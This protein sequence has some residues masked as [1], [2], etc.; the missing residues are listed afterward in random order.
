MSLDYLATQRK[1]EAVKSEIDKLI[2]Y[3]KTSKP[4]NASDLEV[5]VRLADI[6]SNVLQCDSEKCLNSN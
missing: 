6:S 1:L 2:D 5:Y 3:L 4:T